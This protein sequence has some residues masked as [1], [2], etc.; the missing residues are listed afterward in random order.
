MNT[1][2]FSQQAVEDLSPQ[3]LPY[4]TLWLLLCVI[5]MLVAFI[6]LRDKDLRHRLDF[7][8][9]G[10]K[11]R[12][13]RTRLRMRLN[14]AKNKRSLLLRDLGGRCWTSRLAIPRTA[15]LLH[16]ID[17]WEE[18]R[19]ERQSGLKGA[20]AKVLEL[21]RHMDE[22]RVQD[23]SLAKLKETGHPGSP[24]EI[25]R[26]RDEERRIRKEIRVQERKIR[27]DQSAVKHLEFEKGVRLEAL[28]SLAD[29]SRPP[30]PEFQ[31]LYVEI[32]AVNRAILHYLN[33]IENLF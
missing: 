2:A 7:Y 22:T 33:E 5:L 29:E 18:K 21:Q 25:H 10:A 13:Q 16:E 15:T 1:A 26:I 4:W 8:L 12:M 19:L 24:R 6:F 14:K 32:D 3:G 28:G 20:L 9:S 23:R 31:N 17:G 27:T 11:R 30:E